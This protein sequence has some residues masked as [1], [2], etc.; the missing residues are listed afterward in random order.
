L[1]QYYFVGEQTQV[2]PSIYYGEGKGSMD[3]LTRS[4][5]VLGLLLASC[6]ARLLALDPKTHVSQYGH[7]VWRVQDGALNAAPTSIVQT[8]DGYIWIGTETGLLRFDGVRFVPWTPPGW[9]Q[10]TNPEVLH[11]LAASDGTL[12][13]GTNSDVAAWKDGRLTIVPQVPRL[14]IISGLGED[15]EH[16]IWATFIQTSRP[17]CEVALKGAVCFGER[18]GLAPLPSGALTVATDGSLDLVIDESV[19]NW[20]HEQGRMRSYSF[21]KLRQ[22]AQ[23]TADITV[24]AR[25]DGSLLAGITIAGKG[26]GLQQLNDGQTTAYMAPGLDGSSLASQALM[27]DRS[28]TLWI[29]TLSSGLV[30]VAGARVDHYTAKEGLSGDSVRAFYEDHEGNVWVAS[31]AG[32]DCFHDP[33]VLTWSTNEGLQAGDVNTIL[34]ARNGSVLVGVND[35]L[36]VLSDGHIERVGKAQGLPDKWVSSLAEAEP[37]RYWIGVGNQ[38]AIY[39][40]RTVR[41]SEAPV[42][43]RPGTISSIAVDP[44]GSIWAVIVGPERL[45]VH[46][47]NGKTESF[48]AKAK[49]FGFMLTP[50]IKSGIWMNGAPGKLG[51][52]SGEQTKWFSL[53]ADN[54]AATTTRL[55]DLVT[56]VDGSVLAS[57]GVGVWGIRNGKVRR[58]GTAN[59]LP[60]QTANSL[61]LSNKQSLL[62]RASCGLIEI[63]AKALNRW[64]EN[65]KVQVPYR[66]IDSSDGVHLSGPDY[67]PHMSLA[68]DGRIWMANESNIQVFDPDHV[69]MNRVPPPV[70]IEEIVTDHGRLDSTTDV[71][72]PPLIRNLEIHYTGLSF[73]LPQKVK[74]RYMLENWDSAWQEPGTRRTA[75]YQNLKP[76]HYRFHVVAANNDGVWNNTGDSLEF[77]VQPAWFQT[78]W[79]HVLWIAF[80][81][82]AI[83]TVYRLRVRSIA[84]A[85]N[86][87]F[88]ERL[89]ERTRLALELHDTFLQTVQGSK[90]VADDALDLTADQLRMRHA[91]EKLSLWLGQAVSEGRAALHALRVS[92]AEKNHL[93]EFLSRTANEHG[94]WTSIAVALSVIGEARDLHPIVRDELARIA[95]E[96][97]RNACQHSSASHLSIE[98]RY[99]HDLELCLKDDGIGIDPKVVT[100]GKAGHFGIP[101]MKERSA[102]I[103]AKIT[104]RSSRIAGTQISLTVPGNVVYR[105]KERS[106]KAGIQAL[107]FWRTHSIAEVSKDQDDNHAGRE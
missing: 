26:L 47:R 25:P 7:S 35:T 18:D 32:L 70:H 46:V 71:K 77:D 17:L 62:I 28:G 106:L 41:L 20:S 10:I 90:M 22:L 88:D 13:I 52:Y 51:Y 81:C 100:A 99:G 4:R 54:G 89:D 34:A 61:I 48:S 2:R 33:K 79:F 67:W 66:L 107:R 9:D 59:G 27:T 85:I 21:P 29:G 78:L 39:D 91:L 103:R 73:T 74:F 5:L 12:W 60:C 24:L 98:I 49:G 68:P 8:G 97:I 3:R 72:L 80:V 104:I 38:L 45:L 43:K 96:G 56:A 93:A 65:P 84:K 83:W 76:G 64:W 16:R 101:G 31:D 6:A 42:D 14:G 55:T 82:M 95:E 15:H 105:R 50:D 94:Q 102:R 19:I 1:S 30:R 40:G 86:A 58:L 36:E 87:R 11:L 44:D 37:G 69:P 23:A 75:F 57:S 63:E 53:E 92:T